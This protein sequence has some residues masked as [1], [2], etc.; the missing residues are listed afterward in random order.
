MEKSD[1]LALRR[2]HS[3]SATEKAWTL[4]LWGALSIAAW[5][6]FVEIGIGVYQLIKVL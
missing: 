1:T 3:R 6:L 4:L 2:L 5:V